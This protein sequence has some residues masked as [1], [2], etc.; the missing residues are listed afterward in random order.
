MNQKS[1]PD[2]AESSYTE[3][4]ILGGRV[5]LRQPKKGFRASIDSVFL[6]AAVPAMDNETVLDVG[7]G[8]GT[9][10]LCLATRVNNV[11]VSAIE[12]LKENV[13]YAAENIKLN[14]MQNR[15]EILHG[16]LTKAPPRLAAGTFSHVMANPPFFDANEG[17][18]SPIEQ[19]KM[20]N[21]EI[22]ADFEQ[23]AKFCYLMVRPKGTITFIHRADRLDQILSYFYG[24]L[25]DINVYPLWPMKARQAK[26]VIVQGVRNSMGTMTLSPGMILHHEDNGSFTI[27]A[28]NILRHAKGLNLQ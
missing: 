15:V 12:I 6:A 24:K 11:K 28:E 27:E 5:L 14:Q 23:W 22:S 13:K 19:K 26:R 3:N 4:Y 25:G 20:G 21:H 2:I 1:Q 7:S 10:A 18:L 16:N 8:V 9:A 17:R